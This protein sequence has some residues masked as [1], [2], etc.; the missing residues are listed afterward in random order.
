MQAQGHV[1]RACEPGERIGLPVAHK[2]R[3]L[4]LFF[5]YQKN[6]VTVTAMTSACETRGPGDR[7]PRSIQHQAKDLN[8]FLFSTVRLI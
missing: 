2:A 8:H 7:Y 4:F 6:S 1:H 3:P 5:V